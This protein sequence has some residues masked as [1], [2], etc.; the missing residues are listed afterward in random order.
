M[1]VY[2]YIY[3]YLAIYVIGLPSDQT[4]GNTSVTNEAP[5][6]INSRPG[7][8]DYSIVC[9]TILYY[10]ILHYIEPYYINFYYII[11]YYSLLYYINI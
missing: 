1:C 10:T 6:F 11:L 4:Y 2:I 8:R 5:R 7:A 3:T 9:Y